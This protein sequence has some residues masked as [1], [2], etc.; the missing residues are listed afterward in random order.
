[1]YNLFINSSLSQSAGHQGELDGTARASAEELTNSAELAVSAALETERNLRTFLQ[2]AAEQ[3]Q[4][5]DAL[6]AESFNTTTYNVPG[7]QTHEVVYNV[8][9]RP[10]DTTVVY[11]VP[12]SQP[13]TTAGNNVPSTQ[14]DDTDD[15][16]FNVPGNELDAT[17][18]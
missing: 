3:C 10:P 14:T 8:P 12:I 15:V 9:G 6:L 1:M 11:T 17:S 2:N 4:E 13:D 5:Q 7:M 16:V 18:P